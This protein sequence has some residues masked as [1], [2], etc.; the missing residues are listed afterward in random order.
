MIDV[1]KREPNLV[2][3]SFDDQECEWAMSC[4]GDVPKGCNR[5]VR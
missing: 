3:V 1:C 5:E 4:G 2:M